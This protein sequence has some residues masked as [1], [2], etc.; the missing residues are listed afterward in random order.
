M[1]E[2]HQQIHSQPS[3]TSELHLACDDTLRQTFH[4]LC[5]WL[6]SQNLN[7]RPHLLTLFLDKMLKQ[8]Q[9]LLH[10]LYFQ[11]MILCTFIWLAPNFSQIFHQLIIKF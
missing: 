9:W 1:S 10:V 7:L 2:E 6:K 3:F 8:E 11:N 5:E 4:H